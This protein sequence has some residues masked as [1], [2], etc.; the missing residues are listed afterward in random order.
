[1][2]AQTRPVNASRFEQGD[3][4]QG[5]D[6]ADLVDSFVSLADTTAQSITSDFRAA[7]LITAGKVSAAT[8]SISSFNASSVSGATVLGE[9]ATF[10]S[11]AVGNLSASNTIRTVNLFVTTS[12]NLAAVT[13]AGAI[14]GDQR[15]A[16]STVSAS[17]MIVQATAQFSNLFTLLTANTVTPV[18][19]E[20]TI[21]SVSGKVLPFASYAINTTAPACRGY[22]RIRVEGTSAVIP[23]WYSST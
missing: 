8:L 22:I 1:V 10:T 4:P 17:S 3:A 7:N 16:F 23:Y 18:T 14:T 15:A 6:F 9:T 21:A 11:A 19:V 2:T 20:N 5:T 13:M 12:A